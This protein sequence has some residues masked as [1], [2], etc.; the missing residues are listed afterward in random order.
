MNITGILIAAVIVAVIGL[1]LGLFLG[2]AGEKFKVEV[3]E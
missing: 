3:D 1:I 2:V